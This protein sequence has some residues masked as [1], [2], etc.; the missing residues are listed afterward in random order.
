MDD[1]LNE[2]L[3]NVE[4]TEDENDKVETKEVKPDLS[5]ISNEDKITHSF[6]KQI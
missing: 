5:K 4:T 3:S 1:E 2:E 6:K